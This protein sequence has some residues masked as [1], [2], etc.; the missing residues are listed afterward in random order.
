M[1]IL[2]LIEPATVRL[3]EPAIP[4][5][6]RFTAPVLEIV[7]RPGPVVSVGAMTVNK[8]ASDAVPNPTLPFAKTVIKVVVETPPVV[9]AMV[10]SGMFA[11]VPRL[12]WM[13]RKELGVLVPMPILPT[14]ATGLRMTSRGLLSA[15]ATLVLPLRKRYERAWKVSGIF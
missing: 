12:F 3:P 10:R 7:R 11:G 4:A 15:S 1:F 14:P 6:P 5:P 2:A 9:E 8:F 13:E